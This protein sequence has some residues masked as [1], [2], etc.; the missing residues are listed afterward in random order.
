MKVSE[1]IVVKIKF[2]VNENNNRSRIMRPAWPTSEF[3]KD[4]KAM[5]GEF[6]EPG[7]E[8]KES[9]DD[10]KEY[11][12]ESNKKYEA[13]QVVKAYASGGWRKALSVIA[14]VGITGTAGVYGLAMFG[15]AT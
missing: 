8:D 13:E 3:S 1:V 6:L 7:E 2:N 9:Y 5:Y 10:A 14:D 15:L 12:Q 4:L 11:L